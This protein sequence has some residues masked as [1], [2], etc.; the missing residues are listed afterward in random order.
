MCGGEE[1]WGRKERVRDRREREGERKKGRGRGEGGE[2]REEEEACTS[3]DASPQSPLSPP[4]LL[5]QSLALPF[6]FSF[7]LSSPHSPSSPLLLSPHSLTP[8]SLKWR[9]HWIMLPPPHLILPSLSRQHHSP[10]AV[11]EE[12]EKEKGGRKERGLSLT[13]TPTLPLSLPWTTQASFRLQSLGGGLV[14]YR[15]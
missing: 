4:F 15:N 6:S 3:D 5:L 10:P 7:P 14:R 1:E 11:Q 2:G 13:P 8:Y 9:E 12:R